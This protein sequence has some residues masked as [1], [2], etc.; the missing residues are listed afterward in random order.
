MDEA[1][2]SLTREWLTK[3]AHDLENARIVSAVPDGPLD[4]AIF[5]CQQ[6]AEKALKGWLT[7]QSIALEKTHDV[8]KLVQQATE[9]APEFGRFVRAAEVLTP[10]AAAFRYPG[11]T[12]EPMPAREEFDE[13]LQHAQAIHDFVLT[14]LPPEARP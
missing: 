2:A 6:A 9:S 13:A 14:L 1:L 11:L 7:A 5:H 8:R 4:T 12:A 3:A 10:Y